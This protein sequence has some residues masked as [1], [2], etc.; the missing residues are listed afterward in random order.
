MNTPDAPGPRPGPGPATDPYDDAAPS[1]SGGLIRVPALTLG[2]ALTLVALAAAW[3]LLEEGPANR[4]REAA[5][6]THPDSVS[7]LAFAPDGRTLAAASDDGLVTLWDVSSRRRRGGL[8]TRRR[9]DRFRYSLALA[10][11]GRALAR[12]N[13]D[14]TLDLWSLDRPDEPQT[15]GCG[16]DPVGSV[17]YAPDGATMATVCDGVV[18]LWDATT[19]RLRAT[20]TRP[21]DGRAQG[22][23]FA[24]DGRTLAA[25]DTAHGVTLWD[26]PGLRVRATLPR[27]TGHVHLV[28]FAPDGAMLA[29][30]SGAGG[31]DGGITLWDVRIGQPR[32]AL[33]GRGSVVLAM[34]FAPDGG[35]LASGWTDGAVQLWDLTSGRERSSPGWHGGSVTALAF[36]PGGS[37][38][39]SAGVDGVVRLWDV[40]AGRVKAPDTSWPHH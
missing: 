29:A 3:L 28:A 10:P 7:A 14:G 38:L 16:T 17:S 5:S 32:A 23:A 2:T 30:A 11:D 37:M 24:P 36:A 34:A 6:L 12:G 18:K 19:G 26:V 21:G 15:L 39:V 25:G 8:R 22:V 9:M 1:G 27:Q 35:V 13:P 40:R 20:L 31:Q 33:P 4:A